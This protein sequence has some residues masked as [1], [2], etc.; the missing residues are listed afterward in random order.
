[1][2]FFRS[3]QDLLDHN[4]LGVGSGT[5]IFD[6]SDSP[7]NNPLSHTLIHSGFNSDLSELFK[8]CTTSQ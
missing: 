3:T 7:L 8:L 6:S 4:P 1:M 2:E 5:C